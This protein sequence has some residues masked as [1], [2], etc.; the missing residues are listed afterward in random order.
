[1]GLIQLQIFFLQ[2]FH[3]NDLI[4]TK[5]VK[6]DLISWEKIFHNFLYRREEEN[7]EILTQVWPRKLKIWRKYE[8][9][10][11]KTRVLK[12][13]EKFLLEDTVPSHRSFHNPFTQFCWIL[14]FI[15]NV[16][17]EE[18]SWFFSSNVGKKGTLIS[19]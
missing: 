9:W 5:P 15:K 14:R 19:M 18:I 2:L 4:E 16:G 3:R 13:K 6:M 1:M 8:L 12:L 17:F 7:L 11:S 10:S